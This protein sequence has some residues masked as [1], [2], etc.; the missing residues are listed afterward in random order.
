MQRRISVSTSAL[1]SPRGEPMSVSNIFFT[2][3]RSSRRF[4]PTTCTLG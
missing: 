3:G 4:V 1:F 2:P